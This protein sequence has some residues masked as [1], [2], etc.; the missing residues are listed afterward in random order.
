M[1]VWTEDRLSRLQTMW[2]AGVGSA[3]IAT[4][5]SP[6]SRN[7]VMG[8]LNRLGLMGRKGEGAM[9]D[10][11]DHEVRLKVAEILAEA[12]ARDEDGSPRALGM[13]DELAVVQTAIM[14]GRRS[15]RVIS[16][17]CT[18]PAKASAIVAR[19]DETGIWPED[20]EPP[21]GWFCDPETTE[22]AGFLLDVMTLA[23]IFRKRADDTGKETFQ[24]TSRGRAFMAAQDAP[25]YTV[26]GLPVSKAAGPLREMATQMIDTDRD[27]GGI[28][29]CVEGMTAALAAIEF[30]L[31][32][33]VVAQATGLPWDAVA[34]AVDL[35][36]TLGAWRPEMREDSSV[37][38]LP[39]LRAYATM[40]A[41]IMSA[42]LNPGTAA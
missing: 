4:V 7:A 26:H 35:V 42:A 28:P 11:S 20:R 6:I 39:S 2:L 40:I 3:G 33:D 27:T 34:E 19:M 32:R 24:I 21:A 25:R 16:L 18:D 23:G 9:A 10:A 29:Y 8:R 14:V 12:A 17:S 15:P 41:S 38:D 22:S 13:E 30:D 36:E 1:T 31:D 37:D 5:L